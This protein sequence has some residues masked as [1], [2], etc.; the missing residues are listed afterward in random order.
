MFNIE[1]EAWKNV[2]SAY[3]K[4]NENTKKAY[5]Q[6]FPLT[7]ISKTEEENLKSESF[8][9]NYIKDLTFVIVEECF[10]R[11]NNFLQKGDGSFRDSSLVSPILF[12]V[13]QILGYKIYNLYEQERNENIEVYYAGNYN[14]MDVMYK[15][16]YDEFYNSINS[17]KNDFDYYLKTD[18]SN[19]FSNINVNILVEKIDKNC[20]KKGNKITINSSELKVLKD[21]LE[22]AGFGKFPTIENSVATSFLATYVYLD[23]I[24]NYIYEYISK[25]K[26]EDSFKMIRYVDDLYILFNSNKINKNTKDFCNELRN[27]YSSILKKYGL[28]LNNKKFTFT[29]I[30]NIENELKKSLYS[31]N[32]DIKDNSFK[33]FPDESF[34][35]FITKLAS[36]LDNDYITI[37]EYN[38]LINEY[39][40]DENIEYTP[41]EI[42]NYFIYGSDI[43]DKNKKI[44]DSICQLIE[45]DIS[46]ISLDPKRLTTL[47]LKTKNGRAIRSLLNSLF[48][49]SRN[50]PWNTY[51][52]SIAVHY[53]IQRG[54]EHSDLINIL[55]ENESDL[56]KFYDYFCK[57]SFMKIFENKLNKVINKSIPII[58]GK[59]KKKTYFLYLMYK[60]EK[61]KNNTL[62]E[63][64]FFKNY[65]DRVTAHLEFKY[66]S[67][68]LKKPNFRKFYKEQ[69]LCKFY[70]CIDCSKA[71]LEK[72]HNIRNANPLSHASAELLE[73]YTTEE[74]KRN[75][76][77]LNGLIECYIENKENN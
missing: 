16:S 32:I 73:K 75:I 41:I 7:K 64:N 9:K 8:F 50:N 55:G 35:Q 3:F 21:I 65:F 4:L 70:N 18:L 24:D 28:A 59:E 60:A 36:I 77:D 47:V 67:E 12:L 43:I 11:T 37:E 30:E 1:Y 26:N 45:K 48:K 62:S 53:L 5:L 23:E 72:A 13:L 17:K 71:V 56:K 29:K 61:E 25:N 20:N 58:T 22:Y 27:Q 74:I 44:S 63:F 42:F 54:F 6:F 46:F 57:N 40:Y 15:K 76:E 39:F 66:S 2:C 31:E 19:F 69:E 52:T 51:D 14:E 49:R 34:Y 33:N 10:F 68:K 38:E